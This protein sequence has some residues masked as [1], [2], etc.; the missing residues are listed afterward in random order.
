MSALIYLN[1]VW[2]TWLIPSLGFFIA[3]L[4]C[5]KF[6]KILMFHRIETLTHR[7][8]TSIVFVQNPACHAGVHW[9]L[10]LANIVCLI[11]KSPRSTPIQLTQ[12]C[13]A[14]IVILRNNSV[15]FGK[16]QLSLHSKF[17]AKR[18]MVLVHFS[19]KI[20]VLRSAFRT[21]QMFRSRA[22][23][24]ILQV[25]ISSTPVKVIHVGTV[26]HSWIVHVLRRRAMH[27]LDKTLE[28]GVLAWLWFTLSK[29]GHCLRYVTKVVLRYC[30]VK[31]LI[32]V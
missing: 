23:H 6:S 12:A 31:L 1:H 21:S 22:P 30:F 7:L 15:S 5:L 13:L 29:I 3:L 10:P 4:S 11:V 32:L 18:R 28:F 9:L 2:P 17:G 20:G 25:R 16:L 26:G 19:T 24:M 27:R 8:L 14:I